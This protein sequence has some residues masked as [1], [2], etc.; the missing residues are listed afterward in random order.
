M[1]I[2]TLL[3]LIVLGILG[4]SSWLKTRQPGASTNLAKL[5][6]FEG[7]I[8]LIGLVW[9]IVML[10]QWL[11]ALEFIRYAGSAM[12]LGLVMILV[13]IALSLILAMPV[14]RSLFGA[15]NF[16]TKL[17][18]FSGKLMPY[19]VGLGFACL[20]LAVYLLTTLS[21]MRAF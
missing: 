21:S 5:E 11:Q 10:L 2:V 20:V 19:K 1:T 3:L 9:G 17:A 18:E 14:L 13:I 16:T 4:I 12:F 15:N 7:W 8:G 6:Q